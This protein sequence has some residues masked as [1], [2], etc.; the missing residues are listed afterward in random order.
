MPRRRSEAALE[1]PR[2]PP[3][4]TPEGRENQLVELAVDLAEKQLIEGTASSQVISH[5]LKLGSSREK[6]EQ[7]RLHYE[8]EL[9]QAKKE[10]L[11]RAE[12]MEDLFANA[13]NAMKSY[14]G[15]DHDDDR[16]ED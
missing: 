15:E 13:L 16:Y 7:E 9:L 10:A 1:K 2:R 8:N 5:F 4:K 12:R 6:L 14:K 11:E 3:A